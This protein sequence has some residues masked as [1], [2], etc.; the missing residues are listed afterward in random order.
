MATISRTGYALDPLS[1][2]ERDRLAQRLTPEERYVLFDHGTE[3]PFCGGLLD[4]KEPGV[5]ACRLCSLP[6]FESGTKFE[7]GTGWPSFWQPAVNDNVAEESDVSFFMH[8]TE[9]LCSK[10]DAH[11]GHV[12]EDG[13]EPTG[14]RYCINSASLKFEKS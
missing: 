11:L 4:N 10:C 12:F 8:R 2:S 7:S 3:R 9:V 1:P 6:L 13:P 14:L 5:Y